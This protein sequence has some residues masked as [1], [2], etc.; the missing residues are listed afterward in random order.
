MDGERSHASQ[1]FPSHLPA[2]QHSILEASSVSSAPVK[3]KIPCLE[4]SLSAKT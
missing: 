1:K 3:V 2:S 4:V